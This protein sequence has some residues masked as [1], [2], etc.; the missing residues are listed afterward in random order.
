[1]I[2]PKYITWEIVQ[3]FAK[4]NSSS[5]SNFKAKAGVKRYQ[6]RVR[7]LLFIF[8]ILPDWS[9]S[10]NE[11]FLSLS[12]QSLYQ[13]VQHEQVDTVV[14][15]IKKQKPNH[16]LARG[17]LVRKKSCCC[18]FV[19]LMKLRCLLTPCE[20]HDSLLFKDT[21]HLK[22]NDLS[23]CAEIDSNATPG[24]LPILNY[25]RRLSPEGVLFSGCRK[26]KE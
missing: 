20:S 24:V 23:V 4:R 3:A 19:E 8:N 16:T 17:V 7:S 21:K 1:M 9:R 2:G 10:W 22:L 26:I 14:V 18:C 25:T 5:I 11:L 13:N 15:G 12:L 6:Q